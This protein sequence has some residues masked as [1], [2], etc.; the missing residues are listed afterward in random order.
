[1]SDLVKKCVLRVEVE[2]STEFKS[3]Q[4]SFDT[5]YT[6]LSIVLRCRRCR[7]Y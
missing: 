3:K 6:N 4:S 1:M 5:A 7:S 2:N